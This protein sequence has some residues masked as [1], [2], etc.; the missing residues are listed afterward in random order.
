MERR[1]IKDFAE[2]LLLVALTIV[3]LTNLPEI[4][5]FVSKVIKV[6]RPFIYGLAIAYLLMPVCDKMRSRLKKKLS[7][8]MASQVSVLIIMVM[9]LISMLFLVSVVLPEISRSISIIIERGKYAIENVDEIVDSVCEKLPFLEDKIRS[10]VSS[11]TNNVDGIFNE[12]VMNSI[13]SALGDITSSLGQAIKVILD[14]LIGI[15]VACYMMSAK[16][17]FKAQSVMVIE[18]LCS[19]KVKGV[20]MEELRLAHSI[21]SK[22][23]IGKIID[24]LIIG[25]MCFVI[26]M[27]VGMPYA[28]LV[29]LIVGITNVIPFFGPFIG[30]IPSAFIILTEDPMKC[31]LFILIILILQ[32]FDGNVLGPKILGNCTGLN[33]FWVLFSIILFGGIFGVVG[34][35][36]GVPLFAVIYDVLKKIL[37]YKQDSKYRKLN[38]EVVGTG[39]KRGEEELQDVQDM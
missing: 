36:I 14:L 18:T 37:A 32:Q 9:L 7:D 39:A 38:E 16:D 26:L 2:R 12:K 30:A 3:I 33:S 35:V 15:I 24:S 11:A 10:S 1:G 8:R 31:V 6:L 22:F 23:I 17:K 19:D 27:V 21:F 34:M 29:S 28:T 20:L 13:Y 4:V 25:I 5:G